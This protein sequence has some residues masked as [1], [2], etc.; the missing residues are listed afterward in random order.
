[1][2]EYKVIRIIDDK[3]I[4]VN[5]GEEDNVKIND[6]IK[7]FSVGIELFDIDTGE[8][9]GKLET[10]KD[11]VTVV[12]IMPKMCICKKR[13]I[14]YK[15]LF[16][17]GLNDEYKCIEDEKMAVELSQIENGLNDDLTIK[18]GDKARLLKNESTND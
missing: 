12:D 2:N 4:V 17:I 18:L 9:Y 5:C 7:I 8:S 13:N 15:K 16:N 6:K 3:T 11:I 10:T 14:I 1:M